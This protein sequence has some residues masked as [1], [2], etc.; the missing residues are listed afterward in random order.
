MRRGG[1]WTVML[2]LISIL[3][4]AGFN[5]SAAMSGAVTDGAVLQNK[6]IR[7][8]LGDSGLLTIYDKEL[9]RTFHFEE[10]G[11]SL[12]I[13]GR[14]IDSELLQPSRAEEVT[15]GRA[16][17]FRSGPFMIK[18]VYELKPTWRFVSKQLFVTG[19]DTFHVSEVEVF[20]GRLKDRIKSQFVPKTSSPSLKCEDY[21]A[22]LRLAGKRGD[23]TL[24]YKAGDA[25]MFVLVQNP[26]LK[27]RRVG[28]A[29]S[30]TYPADMDWKSQY[31]EFPSDRGCIGTYKLTGRRYPAKMI[32]EW[33]M[34]DAAQPA[35][36]ADGMDFAEVDAFRKCVQAFLL[37]SRKEGTR[38]HVAW[39]ENHYFENM[40]TDEGMD[41]VHRIIDMASQLG[42]KQL[43][44]S[45]GN[46]PI[47]DVNCATDSWGAEHGTWMGL[48][49]QIRKQEWDP[50]TD[51]A[52]QIVQDLIDY[53]RSR[54]MKV[55]AYIYPVLPIE[56]NKEWL[57]D[58]PDYPYPIASLGVRSFQD[59]LIENLT[60]FCQRLGLGGYS[61]DY[62]FMWYEGTSRYAQWWGWRRVMETLRQRL[63]EA[64]IDGRQLY[65]CYGPWI[66]LAGNFPHPTASDE[67]PESFEPF[68]DLS[69]GRVWGNRQRF[70]TWWYANQE[71][72]PVELLPGFIT[73]QTGRYGDKGTWVEYLGPDALGDFR[74]RDWDYLGWRFSLLSSIGTSPLNHTINMIP[75]RD[76]DEFNHLSQEDKAFFRWWFDWTDRNREILKNLHSI[77]SQP[78]VGRIDG[79][80]AIDRDHG[81]VFLFNPNHRKLAAEFVLDDSIGLT[82]GKHFIL[83]ELYPQKGRLFGAPNTGL[84]SRGD[85]VSLPLDGVRAMVFEIQPA[86]YKVT[87]PILFNTVG[88][89][90][91]R[92]DRL[93][94]SGVRGEYG[95][96][97]ELLVALPPDMSIREVSVN[98]KAVAFSQQGNVVRMEAKFAGDYFGHAQQV[99]S[100]DQEFTGGKVTG[101][102]TIPARIFEQLQ[103]RKEQWPIPYT[104]ED[105]KNQWL[106]PHRLL[107][108]VHIA[109]PDDKMTANLK[110]NG[111]T[112]DLVKTY[113]SVTYPNARLFVGFY[114]DV[115]SLEPDKLYQVELELSEMKPGQYQGLFFANVE[116]EYT[117]NIQ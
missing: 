81:Y 50:K 64:V 59:W 74:A 40:G 76:I 116:T 1:F 19:K 32:P 101:S 35:T 36:E 30:I 89:V 33:K 7:V 85:A 86:D 66:W 113:T 38:I 9:D 109:D 14:R 43:I 105:L 52:P 108:Y 29:F 117:G 93:I 2:V 79:T 28:R 6:L 8:E 96:R 27:W 53:S 70:T 71:F 83:K 18:V 10:D 37:F 61:F 88:S 58:I 99:D 82:A 78:A 24:Q 3:T 98:S 97:S 110:L 11:F 56:G 115:S 45:M 106:A 84:W 63:P 87:K 102:F 12:T 67:Q 31:G 20:R 23:L 100:Y 68:A 5:G 13:D 57:V 55:L 65:H 111:Q 15:N 60:A 47:A 42:C 80:A 34:S 112:V 26:F 44:W 48:G 75:A 114:A 103:R 95:T 73:H 51:V 46:S 22:F 72:C 17:S 94:L 91:L 4:F 62:G 39:C 21:G 25:G 41:A 90:D 92:N 104:Q 49:C 107:L 54:N 69:A 77:I 16:Y